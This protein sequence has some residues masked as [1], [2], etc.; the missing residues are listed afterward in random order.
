[1]PDEIQSFVE[2]VREQWGQIS[3]PLFAGVD[4]GEAGGDR[5]VALCRLE[6]APNLVEFRLYSR[7]V[8]EPATAIRYSVVSAVA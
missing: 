1:M 4:Q 6:F 7:R 3:Q 2:Q 5:Y 8:S